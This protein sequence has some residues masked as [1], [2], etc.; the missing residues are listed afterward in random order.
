[1]ADGSLKLLDT[2]DN[3]ADWSN[4][5][6]TTA[7]TKLAGTLKPFAYSPTSNVLA[8]DTP[9][10]TVSN[11]PT[12]AT[13][14]PANVVQASNNGINNGNNSRQTIG[15]LLRDKYNGTRFGQTAWGSAIGNSVFNAAETGSNNVKALSAAEKISMIGNTISN[16]MTAL[17]NR[18]AMKMT[19][20]ELNHNIM[21][22]NRNWEAM[23]RNYNAQLEDRQRY[24]LAYYNANNNGT[25]TRPLTVGEY[26]NKYGA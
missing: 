16:I 26:L 20:Q 13:T 15:Q 3:W 6:T 12:L 1:M 2:N 5:P 11:T 10:V 4:F 9:T 21:N 18:K 8:L 22:N 17:N 23:R 19:K 24:K 7:N 25:Q 14:S